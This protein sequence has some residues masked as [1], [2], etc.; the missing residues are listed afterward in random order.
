MSALVEQD[1]DCL[2]EHSLLIANDD[3]RRF[4]HEQV[5][6][7]VVTINNPTIKIVKVRGGKTSAL[8]GNQRTQIRRNNRQ[9]I[10]NHPFGTRMRILEALDE[11]EA[12]RQFLANLRCSV[13]RVWSLSLLFVVRCV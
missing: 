13:C 2:L 4:E 10:Q 6:Q 12:F 5:L 11:L 9:Y 1:S 8:E 3:I 7:P